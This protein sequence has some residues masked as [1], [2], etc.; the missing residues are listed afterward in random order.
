MSLPAHQSS[1][2]TIMRTSHITNRTKLYINTETRTFKSPF[3]LKLQLFS[4][5]KIYN[6]SKN[7]KVHSFSKDMRKMSQSA[8]THNCSQIQFTTRTSDCNVTF[9][10]RTI[11]V[12]SVIH[13]L[14]SSAPPIDF[15][16]ATGE[17]HTC[18]TN[19]NIVLYYGCRSAIRRISRTTALFL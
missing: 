15:C 14:L 9:S 3:Y 8:L 1:N 10:K 7:T 19:L 6:L 12:F 18:G 11:C 16:M 2:Y 5:C 17:I 4:F 13:P